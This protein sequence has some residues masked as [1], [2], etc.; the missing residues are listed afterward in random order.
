MVLDIPLDM[1]VES[2]VKLIISLTVQTIMSHINENI[3]SCKIIITINK[4]GNY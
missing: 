1:H 3:K 4:H 2:A